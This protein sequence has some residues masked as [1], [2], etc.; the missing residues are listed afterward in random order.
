AAE[1]G[2]KPSGDQI[3]AAERLDVYDAEPTVQ[4]LEVVG[5]EQLEPVQADEDV[6]IGAPAQ[7]QSA[8]DVV[9]RHAGQPAQRAERVVTDR[10]G[11]LYP[12]PRHGRAAEHRVRVERAV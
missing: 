4:I 11:R 6:A 12:L 9:R 2:G 1:I 5:L 10:R 8:R 7:V 3:D